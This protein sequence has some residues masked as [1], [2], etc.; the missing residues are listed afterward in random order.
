[1]NTVARMIIFKS[2]RLALILSVLSSVLWRKFLEILATVIK[3]AP[4]EAVDRFTSDFVSGTP[5][6]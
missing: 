5:D 1:M 4:I 2:F 6:Q 3:T